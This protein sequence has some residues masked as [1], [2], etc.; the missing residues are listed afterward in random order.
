MG[1]K[2]RR[3]HRKFTSARYG[4]RHNLLKFVDCHAATL[5]EE[6]NILQIGVEST[7]KFAQCDC[8]WI[9]YVHIKLMKPTDEQ[10]PFFGAGRDGHKLLDWDG[11]EFYLQFLSNLLDEMLEVS[12]AQII[13]NIVDVQRGAITA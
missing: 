3:I 2:R 1:P 13:A 4:F 11:F 12:F 8:V 10:A 5:D 6:G 7:I 9:K